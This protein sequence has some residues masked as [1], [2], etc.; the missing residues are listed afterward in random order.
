MPS[1]TTGELFLYEEMYEWFAAGNKG[2]PAQLAEIFGVENEASARRTCNYIARKY[3]VPLYANNGTYSIHWTPDQYEALLTRQARRAAGRLI[4]GVQILTDSFVEAINELPAS[5]RK[6]YLPRLEM[7]LA[8]C[9]YL[10]TQADAL[11]LEPP[12][13][14]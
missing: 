4:H 2:T 3:R 10:P 13:K 1:K 6:K 11:L 5:K 7:F 8:T 12:E 9:R 14:E